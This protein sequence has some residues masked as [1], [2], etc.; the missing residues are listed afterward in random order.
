MYGSDLAKHSVLRRFSDFEYLLTSLQEKEETKNYCLPTLPEKRIIGNLDADFIEK[1][2][3][4][5]EGFLR[6]LVSLDK[7]LKHDG[8]IGA[9]LTFDEEKYKAFKQ[10]PSP[11]LDKVKKVYNMMP[12]IPVKKIAE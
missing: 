2:R 3:V 5:L 7:R 11:Y 4:E 6:V 9:F 8:N 12:T 1:R 10:D